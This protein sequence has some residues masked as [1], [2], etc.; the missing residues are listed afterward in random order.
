MNN[1]PRVERVSQYNRSCLLRKQYIQVFTLGAGSMLD[2]PR[3]YGWVVSVDDN[4]RF[5]LNYLKA[6]EYAKTLNN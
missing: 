1:Y 6:K 3:K 5:F 4:H 2:E